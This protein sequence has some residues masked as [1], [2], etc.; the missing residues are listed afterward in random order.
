VWDLLTT[1]ANI[2]GSLSSVTKYLQAFH[3]SSRYTLDSEEGDG[4]CDHSLDI[5]SLKFTRT[6]DIELDN[7]FCTVDEL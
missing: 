4:S 1:G 6:L 7:D 3:S 5:S 2:R